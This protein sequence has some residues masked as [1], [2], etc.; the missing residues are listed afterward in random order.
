MRTMAVVLAA[1]MVALFSGVALAG[2]GGK[3][4]LVNGYDQAM[5]EAK[6]QGKPVMLYFTG[7]G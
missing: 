6:K 4:K 2:G 1:A 7:E 3:L 5:K